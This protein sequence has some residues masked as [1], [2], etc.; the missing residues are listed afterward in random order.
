[1][2]SLQELRS[3]Y[4]NALKE[5][6]VKKRQFEEECKRQFDICD[7][8]NSGSIS[9]GEYLDTFFNNTSNNDYETLRSKLDA[10][11]DKFKIIDKDLDG[12]LTFPEILKFQYDCVQQQEH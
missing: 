2:K 7:K 1:M 6:F 8:N 5:V 11:I 10:Q 3:D 9:I 4:E 12:T